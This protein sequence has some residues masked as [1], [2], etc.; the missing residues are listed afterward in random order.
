MQADLLHLPLESAAFDAAL[1]RGCSHYP[2]PLTARRRFTD[3]LRGSTTGAG[4]R[5]MKRSQPQP[6]RLSRAR[7]LPPQGTRS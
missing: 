2:A 4:A 1:N 5:L 3:L 7:I 6:R